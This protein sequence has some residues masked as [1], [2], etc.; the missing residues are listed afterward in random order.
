MEWNIHHLNHAIISQP[1][2]SHVVHISLDVRS[3]GGGTRL[4]ALE[5]VHGINT[6]VSM[7]KSRVPKDATGGIAVITHSV[8][9]P[10][11]NVALGRGLAGA[12][13]VRS[14][15]SVALLVG[16][17]AN[18]FSVVWSVTIRAVEAATVAF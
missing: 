3:T 17:L 12:V 6:L 14:A 8:L 1:P 5:V 10:L 2:R 9:L 15:F 16:G 18:A 7:G 13:G 11:V 4:T